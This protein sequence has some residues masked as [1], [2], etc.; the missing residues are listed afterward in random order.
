MRKLLTKTVVILFF[1]VPMVSSALVYSG[2]NFKNDEYQ[3]FENPPLDPVYDDKDS[4]NEHRKKV[5]EYLRK[6]E[7]YVENADSD[8]KR[9]QSQRFDAIQRAR[10]EAEKYDLKTSLPSG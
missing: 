7:I 9:I 6:A 5:V 1:T 4:I 8:I 2:S 10:I 3:R